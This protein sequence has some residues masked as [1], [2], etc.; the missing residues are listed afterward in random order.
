M[1]Q[2]LGQDWERRLGLELIASTPQQLD[3]LALI[4]AESGI[5]V[6]RM[7]WPECQVEFISPNIARFGYQASDVLAGLYRPRDMIHP[8]DLPRYSK[9][10]ATLAQP[11][12]APGSHVFRLIGPTG[13]IFHVRDSTVF[14]S[15]EGVSYL[16]G[17]LFDA[18]RGDNATD[19]DERDLIAAFGESA[20]DL[21]GWLFS[22]VDKNLVWTPS[23]YKILGWPLDQ[24][25]N[26]D[27]LLS[28]L[29]D[30]ERRKL[31]EALERVKAT[32]GSVR[33]EIDLN[34]L[35]G[36]AKRISLFISPHT[37]DGVLTRYFGVFR[38]ITEEHNAV[39]MARRAEKIVAVSSIALIEWGAEWGATPAYV[40]KNFSRYGYAADL[41]VAGTIDYRSIVHPGDF[42]RGAGATRELL[43]SQQQAGIDESR[44]YAQRYRL[45]SPEART[46]WV[47]EKLQA[48][49]DAKGQISCQGI[50]ID[51]SEAE[52]QK[53]KRVESSLLLQE[54]GRIAQVGGWRVT[55]ASGELEC[56]SETRKIL[57]VPETQGSLQF[58]P[59]SFVSPET[60]ALLREH[61]V[62]AVTDQLPFDFEI[63]L[64][65]QGGQEKWV[66]VSGVPV[67]VDGVVTR[68]QGILQD[69]SV[70]R[71][72]N[73]KL[74]IFK[75]IVDDSPVILLRLLV[76]ESV[77]VEYVTSNIVRF[78]YQREQLTS[79][80][81]PLENFIHPEDLL[82]IL[83]DLEALDPE[84]KGPMEPRL[85][86]VFTS[87]GEIAWVEGRVH[88][89]DKLADG[90]LLLEAVV[91][92]V[93]ERAVQMKAERRLQRALAAHTGAVEVIVRAEEA[94]ELL[95]GVC[96]LLI[97]VA[98]YD[99]AWAGIIQ[100]DHPRQ[101]LPVAVAGEAGLVVADVV[102]SLD[103]SSADHEP[104]A[105]AALQGEAIFSC[106]SCHRLDDEG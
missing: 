91:V 48:A 20:D 84:Q 25:A 33:C 85:C 66:R 13:Q 3:Q 96:D 18:S 36:V 29:A 94:S 56:S 76:G 101:L 28:I 57:G 12:A 63:P 9:E 4:I 6:F 93:T 88:K 97:E 67:V 37:E 104:G 58:D 89:L 19:V 10:L 22:L 5:V 62:R 23:T 82:A 87:A 44:E 16:Q 60:G 40:S 51:R 90:R 77:N 100:G 31:L 2:V 98:G 52:I 46:F 49:V 39:L 78:G 45:I 30:T 74:Q 54:A 79:G 64:V 24:A 71:H 27:R 73:E 17:A 26:A 15:K 41:I 34:N 61:G 69:I 103:P 53:Q 80:E 83:A 32:L 65:A 59:F 11:G 72:E 35:A 43:K 92:D 86:R 38:D 42:E 8:D 102:T 14:S 21:G 68:L 105:Y 81:L 95:Q 50:L 106:E 70:R 7:T 1:E 47:E 55:L 75:T 99:F